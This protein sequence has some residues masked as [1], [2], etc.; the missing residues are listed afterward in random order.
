MS[1][2]KC[3]L[4]NRLRIPN[5]L[6]GEVQLLHRLKH[7]VGLLGVVDL[8]LDAADHCLDDLLVALALENFEFAHGF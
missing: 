8:V 2:S 7:C 4:V 1:S 3:P 5:L 6:A